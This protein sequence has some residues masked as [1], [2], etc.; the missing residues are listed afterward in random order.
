MDQVQDIDYERDCK[1]CGKCCSP[2]LHYQGKLVRING[3]VC[4]YLGPDNQC[5]VY[6]KRKSIMGCFSPYDTP[7]EMRPKSCVFGGGADV[8]TDNEAARFLLN[9]TEELMVAVCSNLFY[10][11]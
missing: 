9:P 5:V 4:K 2:I 3:L 11:R 8:L 1:R 7:F 10:W 6:D